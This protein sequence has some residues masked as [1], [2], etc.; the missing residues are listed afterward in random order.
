MRRYLPLYFLTY[1]MENYNNASY[2]MEKK[3]TLYKNNFRSHS[4]STVEKLLLYFKKGFRD[5]GLNKQLI[6]F[7]I[8]YFLFNN[9][10]ILLLYLEA[11]SLIHFNTE[12]I[13]KH[14]SCYLYSAFTQT[15]HDPSREFFEHGETLECGLRQT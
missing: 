14:H 13:T 3:Q 12:H 10:K 2:S 6:L 11:T 8:I 1:S 9:Y 4:F 5:P 7:S 15:K